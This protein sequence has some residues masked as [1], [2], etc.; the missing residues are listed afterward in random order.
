MAVP[1]PLSRYR[2]WL[3]AARCTKNDLIWLPA[4]SLFVRDAARLAAGWR[5][6]LLGKS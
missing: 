1:D 2:G 6:F 5:P 4:F 3:H